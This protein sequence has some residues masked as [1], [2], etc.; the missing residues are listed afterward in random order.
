MSTVAETSSPAADLVRHPSLDRL[1]AW[2][3]A[4]LH[5]RDADLILSDPD[6]IKD[7]TGIAVLP[8]WRW[9]HPLIEIGRKGIG[10]DGSVFLMPIR[11]D[12]DGGSIALVNGE[13]RVVAYRSVGLGHQT[14]GQAKL[15]QREGAAGKSKPEDLPSL[16]SPVF[17]G[18]ASRA[19][20]I[21]SLKALS[22]AGKAA[23]WELVTFI[24]PEVRTVTLRA[25][26]AV[27]NEMGLSSGV[28]VPVLD[29]QGLESV[30]NAML[31]GEE[32]D[33]GEWKPGSVFRLI[34]LCLT[35]DCFRKVEPLRYMVKHLRR[36]AETA[37]RKKIGD[38][39]IGPKVREVARQNP[40]AGVEEI[41][42]LY[43]QVYPRDRLSERR[44]QDALSVGPDAMAGAC[45]LAIDEEYRGQMDASDLG[46]A[47]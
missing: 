30:I 2:F 25:H 12:W 34:D 27:S 39:H 40:R 8:V 44:A 41:V 13:S 14:A 21:N 35:P 45:G 11:N 26:G 22:E 24:E 17:V 10:Y 23:R 42:E 37:I 46:E 31:L 38:P 3:Q 28:V 36:D 47:A 7:G 20:T 16:S 6:S 43:R 1:C 33:K 32:N 29:G 9:A 4:I 19:R 15:I 5:G 18:A